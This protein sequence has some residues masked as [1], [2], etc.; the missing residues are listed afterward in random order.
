MLEILQT[1]NYENYLGRIKQLGLSE[2][3]P[4]VVEADDSGRVTGYGI[5]HLEGDRVMIDE[6]SPQQ[7]LCLFDGI[8]RSILF[9]SMMKGIEKAEFSE[10][11]RQTAKKMGFVKDDENLLSSVTEFMSKC[12]S[13]G[14]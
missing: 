12:K 8:T 14:K 4:N 1:K 10:S 7:D 11:I 2:V 13:C 6:V 3:Y 5:Y 9:L